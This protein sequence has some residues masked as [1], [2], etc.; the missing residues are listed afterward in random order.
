MPVTFHLVYTT[1]SYYNFV[2]EDNLEAVLAR[3]QAGRLGGT[4]R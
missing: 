2:P 3:L 1:C 4:S